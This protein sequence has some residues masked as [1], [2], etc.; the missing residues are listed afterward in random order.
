[1]EVAATA[2]ATMMW[3]PHGEGKGE[4]EGQARAALHRMGVAKPCDTPC[5]THYSLP[6]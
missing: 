5:A 3:W 6:M 2:T 1:M 4:G